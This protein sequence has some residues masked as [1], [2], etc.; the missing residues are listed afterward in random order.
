MS[1]SLKLAMAMVIA[2]VM[3]FAKAS[4]ASA[5]C[6]L[7]RYHE[8]QSYLMKK[9]AIPLTFDTIRNNQAARRGG[10]YAGVTP[11]P[12]DPQAYSSAL[13]NI[14]FAWEGALNSQNIAALIAMSK[15]GPAMQPASCARI[16]TA[17]ERT[18]L[19]YAWISFTKLG[20][21]YMD[22]PPTPLQAATLKAE[23]R[24]PD[25]AHVTRLFSLTAESLGMRLTPFGALANVD[26][27][28]LARLQ[29]ARQSAE[30][31]KPSGVTCRT[32]IY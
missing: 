3:C 30:A 8:V 10:V 31:H 16:L 19:A 25:F 21:R 29:A 27:P 24:L 26:D 4:M 11:C 15:S 2:L 17:S 22:T 28:W 23:Q 20:D 9:E 32:D 14:G 13:Q 12:E 6:G 5:D 18:E 7:S 1:F